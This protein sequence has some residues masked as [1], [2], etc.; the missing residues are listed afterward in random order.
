MWLFVWLFWLL[1]IS[2]IILT[3]FDFF[4]S[5]TSD[6]SFHN[7]DSIWL[8]KCWKTNFP[9]SFLLLLAETS[10]H[11]SGLLTSI[12]LFLIFLHQRITQLHWRS[13][14][15]TESS[16]E[17]SDRSGYNVTGQPWR[18]SWL[19][20]DVSVTVFKISMLELQELIII[21]IN[22]LFCSNSSPNPKDLHSNMIWSREKL[23]ILNPRSWKLIYLVIFA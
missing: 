9:S 10:L 4:L 19:L 6:F 17:A 13:T 14:R 15:G 2:L 18:S 3:Y 16:Q 1:F 20:L 5:H 21:L 23:L 11:S 12:Y 22:G 7:F 8:F